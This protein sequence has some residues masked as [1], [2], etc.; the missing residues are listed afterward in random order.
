MKNN[1]FNWVN[2]RTIDSC[3]FTAFDFTLYR[4]QIAAR[5]L[6]ILNSILQKNKKLSGD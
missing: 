6:E 3:Y 2:I 5:E 4:I 1:Q